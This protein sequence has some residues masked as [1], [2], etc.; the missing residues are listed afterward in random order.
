MLNGGLARMKSARKSGC[1][2]RVKV[3][4]YPVEKSSPLNRPALDCISV[5]AWPKGHH[6][7]T[8]FV[9]GLERVEQGQDYPEVIAA[10]AL[11]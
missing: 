4:V 11:E 10:A 3:R 2:L 5:G 8:V 6:E 1:W 7:L 9:L